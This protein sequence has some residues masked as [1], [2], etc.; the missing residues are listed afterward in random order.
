MHYIHHTNS[1]KSESISKSIEPTHTHTHTQTIHK[2]WVHSLKSK[3]INFHV[4]SHKFSFISRI[5]PNTQTKTET[6][7]KK[8]K[9]FFLNRSNT[10][11]PSHLLTYQTSQIT[12]SPKQSKPIIFF[13]HTPN[14]QIQ[15][16][17]QTKKFKSKSK[18]KS[19]Q[20]KANLAKRIRGTQSDRRRTIGC[21]GGSGYGRTRGDCPH[22]PIPFPFLTNPP[23]QH[24][25]AFS[26]FP[27]SIPTTS[28]INSPKPQTY[29]SLFFS[30]KFFTYA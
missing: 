4:N 20:S 29:F 25:L 10:N 5:S 30:P 16:N 22:V 15:P 21:G 14:N 9:I 2:N 3:S 27:T 7:N 24:S 1:K 18:S 26:P 28:T 17:K 11:T 23:M 12:S 19:K 6:K 13:S 8:Q